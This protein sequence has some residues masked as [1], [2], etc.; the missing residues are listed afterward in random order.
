MI[1]LKIHE[2]L[3]A[4]YNPDGSVLRRQQMRM[5]DILLHVDKICKK[6]NIPYWL[7]SGTLLGAVR[8]G[9]FIPWDDDLDIE[10]MREDYLRFLEVFEDDDDHV[11]HTHE[12]DLHYIMPYAKVRDRH[13][14][15]EEHS[16]GEKFKYKGIFIDVFALEYTHRFLSHQTHMS[17]RRIRKYD[18]RHKSSRFVEWMISLRKR[19]AFASFKMWRA[20]S[21]L[22]PGQQLRYSYGTWCYREPRFE[23]DL[24]PLTTIEFEGYTFPAPH[25]S[26]A[27]LR[28]IYGDYMQL[29]AEKETHATKVEFLK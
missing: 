26:D 2:E 16:G 8:H 19:V 14:I 13:S 18:N 23:S 21:N 28:H 10:M 27:Y 12:N 20:I 9:G 24:F 7:S 4:E 1:D 15:V 17:L 6:H 11:L 3:R 25:D 5:L 22:L 29:P